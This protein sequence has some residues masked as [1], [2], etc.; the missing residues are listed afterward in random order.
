MS[1]PSTD[2]ARRVVAGDSGALDELLAACE[3]D[4]VRA[5]RVP[6]DYASHTPHMEALRDR[7][8]TDLAEL[9]PRPSEIAFYSTLRG[10][11]IDTTALDGDYWYENLRNPVRFEQATRALVA[12]GHLLFV[13]ASA[14]PV[15][16]VGLGQ[17]LDDLGTGGAVGSL[18]RD[19]GGMRRLLLSFAEALVAGARVDWDTYFA[20]LP[21]TVRPRPVDLPTYPF[22]RQRY[23]VTAPASADAASLG[24]AR[25]D[26]PLLG[27][28]V[29]LADDEG[30]LLTTRLSVHTHPWLADHAV[31]GTV[32]LPG[33]AFVELAL[34][35]GHQ[36][37]CD[38][39]DDLTLEA[40]LAL[41]SHGAVRV[42]VRV[43]GPDGSGRRTVGIHSRPA[44][45]DGTP[46]TRHATG[47]LATG[48]D[49][50]P[51]PLA[52]WPPPGARPVDLDG[53]YGRLAALGYAY[54]T[55][56]QGLRSLRQ[57]GDDLYAEVELAEEQRA[58][59][60]R[61]GLHP[62]LLDAALHPL[63]LDGDE[64]RLP[65]SWSGVRLHAVGAVALRVHIHRTGEGSASL[66]VT[67]TTGAPVATV[68]SLA[69][70]AWRGDRP[71]TSRSGAAL[72]ELTWTRGTEP[73]AAPTSDAWAVVGEGL[74]ADALRGDR[75]ATYPGLP[76]L[77]AAGSAE[78]PVP[79]AVFADLTRRTRAD[80]PS[81]TAHDAAHHALRLV[82]AWLA[83]PR[84]QEAVLVLVTTGAVAAGGDEGTGCDPAAATV[85]GL[86]RSAQTEHPGRLVLLDTDGSATPAALAS[87][88]SYG[89]PQLALRDG[90]VLVPRLTRTPPAHTDDETVP[91]FDPDG[92]VLVTGA[93]GTL[94]TLLVRHLAAEHGVRHLLLAGRSGRQAEGAIELEAE[95][96]AH[97]AEVTFVACDVGDRAEVVRLLAAVPAGRPLTGVI[98]AAGVL[99][100]GTVESLTAERLDTVLRPKADGA[101]HLH[102]LTSGLDLDAFVLFSSVVATTGNG[103]QANYGAANAFLDALAHHRRSLRA[104]RR[105]ARPGGCGARPAR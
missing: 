87:A 77:F 3:T 93:T 44:E 84:T 92:T 42:Q 68:E 39:L 2:P 100:D 64:T 73:H 52:P 82:Q 33:T 90:A 36:V 26:H 91:L 21:G 78:E 67:D 102:E 83:E 29:E 89:E 79:D 65:F 104:A 15:L 38:L 41:T 6:V 35:A 76:A 40:P 16:T 47:L 23:W 58:E 85:W 13:E 105:L 27:A 45:D 61:F 5:R 19:D 80:T 57:L 31:L 9:T 50:R 94:G 4:G 12:D 88:L 56:F 14:H 46:W 11:R 103:G 51:R 98:H 75:V 24:L 62:A 101:W 48:S 34:T 72:Y 54:G 32:L 18:R 28:E 55:A 22:Q 74:L 43:G 53:V 96:L 66:R 69:M 70:R 7:L 63:V 25:T 97:G 71:A 20:G 95:L 10:A 17:T 49:D 99:D 37:A 59:A 1:P 8:A 60:A 30:L 86:L 81:A